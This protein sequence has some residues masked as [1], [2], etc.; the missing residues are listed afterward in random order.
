MRTATVFSIIIL[1]LCQSGLHAQGVDDAFILSQTYYEGTA[2]SLAMGNATGAMGGDVTAAC[3]NPAGLGLYRTQELTFSTGLQHTFIS[4]TYYDNREN[5]W[6]SRISIPNFGYVMTMECSN[7]KPLRYLQFA[8]SLTRTNDFNQRSNALGLNPSSSM[9]DNYLQTING[10]DELHQPGNYPGSYLSE[11]Y[12]YD[13][14]L[15]WE[16]YLIDQYQDSLGYFYY[17]SP[18][19]QGNVNQKDYSQTKGRSEEWAFAFGAN[20]KDKLFLGTS[21]GLTHIKRIHSR[22]YSE[23]PRNASS[24]NYLFSSWSHVEE[25]GDTAWGVNLKCG[26]IYF[27]ASW[28]RFGMAWHSRTIYGIGENWST[29][30][31]SVLTG[32]DHA[33]HHQYYSPTL[34]QSYTFRTPHTLVGSTAFFIGQKGLLTTDVEYLNYGTSKFSSESFSFQDT[35]DDIKSM[36][37]PTFNFRLGTEWRWHQYFLRG[38]MAYYGSPYGLAEQ[39]GSVRK[40][41]AGIGYA[42]SDETYWDF[43][44]ELTHAPSGYTPYQYYVDGTNLVQS[45]VQHKWRSKLV[46]TLKI[47]L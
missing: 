21:M 42:I 45:V 17:D 34:Y 1:I 25:L 26:F 40:L 37:R 3:I 29:E 43:A 8:I 7:Y 15:A 30:T 22:T 33:G 4:N 47:K 19:P 2:R 13:I 36:L 14:D 12:P 44:Y 20:I 18:I 28:I 38:G 46:A 23:T 27:P 24:N 31:T 10:I 35:N 5:E 16:T 39:Y 6:K 41:S 9:I 32:T 11:Y